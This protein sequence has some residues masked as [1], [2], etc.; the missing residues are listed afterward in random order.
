MG[1]RLNCHFE[2]TFGTAAVLAQGGVGVPFVC[3]FSP[4]QADRWIGMP[5]WMRSVPAI[6]LS[7][8]HQFEHCDLPYCVV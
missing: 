7:A 1:R 8:S 4:L 6:I 5:F 3:C 2:L